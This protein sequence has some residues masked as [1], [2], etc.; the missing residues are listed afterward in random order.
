MPSDILILQIYWPVILTNITIPDFVGIVISSRLTR[1]YIQP[2]HALSGSVIRTES[3]CAGA[4][5]PL[6]ER[7]PPF[8]WRERIVF[9]VLYRCCLSS[10]GRGDGTS[11]AFRHGAH[12]MYDKSISFRCLPHRSIA[13]V[14]W[15][16]ISIHLNDV[17]SIM[18]RTA[19][20][21]RRR[22]PPIDL[23]HTRVR[24]AIQG[25]FRH[26]R[27]ADVPLKIFCCGYDLH[28]SYDIAHYFYGPASTVEAKFPMDHWLSY[29]AI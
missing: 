15:R 21:M 1:L 5:P 11:R 13:K 2:H 23:L 26:F 24:E 8:V 6:R 19:R 3:L 9:H 18:S 17:S 4:Q 20:H 7:G 25:I 29:T 28:H 16:S 10:C 22:T 12:R 14:H 27:L